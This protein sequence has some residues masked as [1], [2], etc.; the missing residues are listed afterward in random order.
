MISTKILMSLALLCAVASCAAPPPRTWSKADATEQQ[1]A[2]DRAE[3]RFEA[4]KSANQVDNSYRSMLG[5]ELDLNNRRAE[6]YG[7][8]LEARGYT[9]KK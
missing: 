4:I 8:C 3:C 1:F 9:A 6:I 2:K 7:A 5:Q